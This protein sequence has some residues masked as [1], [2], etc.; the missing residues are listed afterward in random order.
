MLLNVFG[1]TSLETWVTGLRTEHDR[2]AVLGGDRH[3]RVGDDHAAHAAQ[4]AGR[5]AGSGGARSAL[6]LDRVPARHGRAVAD[7]H[8]PDV[9]AELHLGRRGDAAGGDVPP[10]GAPPPRSARAGQL[11][12]DRAAGRGRHGRSVARPPPA[13]GARRGDQAGA[14]VDAGRERVGGAR[15]AAPVR[16][17]GPGHGDAQLAAH[18]PAV[19]LRRGQ[20]RQLLLRD[21][22]AQRPRPR[23]AR[24]RVRPAAARP[25]DVHA[26]AGLSLARRSARARAGASRREAR[27]HLRVPHGPRLRLRQGAR[28]RP[29]ADPQGRSGAGGDRDAAHRGALDRHARRTWRRK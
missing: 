13:A 19:R 16:A 11:R 25:R 17:R 12:A 9:P 15:S 5:L 7:G 6:R 26:A 21:G 14:A 1:A 28:L 20:R 18:H 3:P 4:D 10:H 23:V 29:G 2:R 27:Q 22:A 24:P 8:L